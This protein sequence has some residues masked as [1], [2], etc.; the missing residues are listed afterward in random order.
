MSPVRAGDLQ[1]VLL[2]CFLC[3]ALLQPLGNVEKEHCFGRKNRI[4][5]AWIRIELIK[6]LSEMKRKMRQRSTSRPWLH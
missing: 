3:P 2:H 6:T 5:R 4:A 1:L